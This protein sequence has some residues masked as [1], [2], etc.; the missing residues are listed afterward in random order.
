MRGGLRALGFFECSWSGV[1]N[2]FLKS[3]LSSCMFPLHISCVFSCCFSCVNRLISLRISLFH[4]VVFC[5]VRSVKLLLVSLAGAV[6][7]GLSMFAM[8][9]QYHVNFIFGFATHRRNRCLAGFAIVFCCCVCF[10]FLGFLCK[11]IDF[12]FS[13]AR[14]FCFCLCVCCFVVCC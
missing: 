7:R 6:P 13:A 5:C 9:L 14:P 1:E 8:F 3:F 12:P 10:F 4:G 2:T 11:T